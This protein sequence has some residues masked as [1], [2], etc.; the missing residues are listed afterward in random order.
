M[1][2]GGGEI[3]RARRAATA[4][5]QTQPGQDGAVPAADEPEE[6]KAPISFSEDGKL[7]LFGVEAVGRNVC[8]GRNMA[9]ICN[10]ES[11]E[12]CM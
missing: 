6:Q 7:L 1:R 11:D 2:G 12:I 3:G 9:C 4:L 5:R 10:I 8:V